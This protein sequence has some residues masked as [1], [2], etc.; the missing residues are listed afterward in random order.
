MAEHVVRPALDLPGH[1]HLPHI[2]LRV[3]G[4][5]VGLW[6]TTLAIVA[7]HRLPPVPI[8]AGTASAN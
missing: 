2:R 8:I 7:L 6:P 5:S 4:E 3:P 1:L